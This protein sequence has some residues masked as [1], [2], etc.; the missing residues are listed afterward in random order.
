MTSSTEDAPENEPETDVVDADKAALRTLLAAT[1]DREAAQLPKAGEALAYRFP[2]ALLPRP[3]QVLSGY[4]RFRSEIEPGGIMARAAAQGA[5]LALPVIPG[6]GVPLVFRRWTFGEP[7]EEGPFKVMA[8]PASA[9]EVEPDVV[10]T[11]LLGFD[12]FGGRLGYGGGY[13]DRTLEGLRAKKPVLAI[14]V[15]FEIQRLEAVPL[16]PHDQRL[17]WVVTEAAA[18]QTVKEE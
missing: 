8:P 11:P 6:K 5:T 13:Y 16:G 9:P 1:R 3:G 15:A 18:Y 17:D 10:L 4:A 12:H 14:G 2:D 7:L